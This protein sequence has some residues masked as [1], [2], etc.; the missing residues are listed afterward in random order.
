MTD[1]KPLNIKTGHDSLLNEFIKAFLKR[2]G[3]PVKRIN[4]VPIANDGSLRLFSRITG[5][6]S[7]PSFVIME[8]PP[9]NEYLRNENLSYLMI[10]KHLF[11]K[12]LPIPEIYDFDLANGWF[13]LEDMGDTNLQEYALNHPDR[14]ALYEK[15][16]ELLFHLQTKGNEDFDGAWC[17]QTPIYERS[18][19]RKFESDYFRDSFLC[20][21]MG[22]KK[23]WP[24]LENP[25]NYLAEMG[26]KADKNFFLHRDFQSRNIMIEEDKIGIIDWQGGR[27]GP[28]A[29]DLASLLIDPYTKLTEDEKEKI[30]KT[31][32]K[33][34]INH[35]PKWVDPFQRYFPFLAIQRNLQI[36]GAFS[37][38]TKIQGKLFFEK[39]IPPALKS[40]SLLLNEQADPMLKPLK[41][42][43][44]NL[45]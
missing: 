19:M 6:E 22:L 37:Y 8:N 5:N 18:V 41:T 21:Y 27:H 15:I 20:N 4:I 43:V 13:I 45:H 31:Y 16:L 40:L 11:Q 2:K 9:I 34:L 25:F 1:I 30:F 26:S 32:L 42:L 14:P 35:H 38:L 17:Y 28:L 12:G 3:H 29:Y 39:Y 7:C 10:G 24:E 23:D 44:R 36:I 33:I